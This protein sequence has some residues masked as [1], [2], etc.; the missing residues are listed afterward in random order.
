MLQTHTHSRSLQPHP[1]APLNSLANSSALPFAKEVGTIKRW[2]YRDRMRLPIRDE[3]EMENG[4]E[5]HVQAREVANT[6]GSRD[7]CCREAL[8]LLT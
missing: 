4:E 1:E 7:T 5:A 6:Q 3:E 8:M 2:Q